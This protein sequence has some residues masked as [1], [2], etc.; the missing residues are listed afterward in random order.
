M[1]LPIHAESPY[2]QW[3]NGPPSDPSYFPIG[4]WLQSTSP[5]RIASYQ[6]A[7][8]NLYVGLWEGPTETQLANLKSKGMKCICV[9][10]TVGLTS[11]NRSVIVGWMHD[12]EPDNAQW[13]PVTQ[14]YDPPILPS[15]IVDRYNAMKAADPT[16]P[17]FLNLGQ[18]LAWDGWWGRGTQTNHPE[19]YPL[20]LQGC[21]IGSFDIYPYAQDDSDSRYAPV[22]DKP[23]VIAGGVD[24]LVAWTNPQTQ[25][26]WNFVECTNINGVDEATP[27]QVKAEVWMSLVH[28]SNGILYFVHE[29]NPFIE[30]GLL[31]DPVMTA[32]V[33][34]I[35]NEIKSLAPA[36]N[37][38]TVV[39]AATTASSNPNTWL[40]TMVKHQG[41]KAYLFAV[42]M[43]DVTTIAT[44]H[45][46]GLPATATV[47]VINENRNLTAI[48]GTF[49][50]SYS[51]YA[52]H[53]YRVTLPPGPSITSWQTVLTHGD[54]GELATPVA[55]GS[56]E[57][58]LDGLRTLR[59]TFSKA[60]STSS[61]VDG[62]V[63]IVGATS[64]SVPVPASCLSL[65][66]DLTTLT[67]TLPAA[68]PDGDTYT[69]T[70][71]GLVTGDGI[72][73]LTG[74]LTLTV[75]TRAGDVNGDSTVSEVDL[76]AARAA[77]GPVTATNARYDVNRSGAVTGDDLLAIRARLNRP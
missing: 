46:G 8:F 11:V 12:D 17:V 57:S 21:D 75:A 20:Y 27:A 3:T 51:G 45:L 7:G 14:T 48:N 40:D 30:A 56:V 44:L 59:I 15:V 26:R 36:L 69:I 18:G 4:V 13:N 66:G 2:A 68:L 64:G 47:E 23:Y 70:V 29:F 58:R 1:A 16:R 35:N 60:L 38:P 52:V 63:T 54:A 33:T 65:S 34:A 50:D 22:N 42:N 28:G 71:T 61:L 53:L 76:L 6:A 73:P 55:D 25:V 67:V 39:G 72:V 41:G 5:S 24:R 37:S 49:Y 10:N 32:A 19:D 43:R 9:Q 74:D 62:A 31:A 77:A